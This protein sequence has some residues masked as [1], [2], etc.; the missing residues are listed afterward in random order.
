MAAMAALLMLALGALSEALQGRIEDNRSAKRLAALH[1]VLGDGACDDDLLASEEGFDS[2]FAAG[3]RI[4]RR[5]H[6]TCEGVDRERGIAT[7]IEARAS[8]G[9][10]GPIEMLIG[11]DAA[12]RIT[13][14]RV[15]KHAET[16]GLGD[17]IDSARSD[18][19]DQFEGQSLASGGNQWRIARDGGRFDKISGATVTS[20]TMVQTLALVGQWHIANPP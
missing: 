19:I 13:A 15:T 7:V 5:W 10:S 6:A 17:Q 2:T 11:I 12:H 20:R 9:Y 4:L 18:W 14:V 16:P 1:A 8:N 3:V